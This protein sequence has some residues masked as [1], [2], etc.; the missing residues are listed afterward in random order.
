MTFRT[1]SSA[2]FAAVAITSQGAS[3]DPSIPNFGSR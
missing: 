1:L 3:A 2:V